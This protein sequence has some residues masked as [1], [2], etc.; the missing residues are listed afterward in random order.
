ML[1][2]RTVKLIAGV[3]VSALALAACSSNTP[4]A[5][6]STSAGGGVDSSAPAS[7]PADSSAP[8]ESEP[9]ESSAEGT[10]SGTGEALKVGLAFDTGGRG[11]GTFNDSAARGADRAK[12]E[13]GVTV[14]EVE[15]QSDDDRDPNLTLLTG[16]GLDPI[17]TVGFLW[18][19]TL[20]KIAAA[21]PDVTYA[22]VDGYV[23]APN[24]KN[25]GFAEEQGSFLVGAAAALKS[26]DGKIGFI[27]GQDGALIK[28]FELGY[29]AGAKA[30]NPD[31]EVKVQYLGPEGDNSAWGSPDKAKAIAKTWYDEGVDVIYSAAGGSGQGTID[32][33]IEAGEGKWAIGVDSD[34]YLTASPEAQKVILTSMLKRVDEAV[35]QTIEA[36]QNGNLD[37]IPAAFDLSVD[38]VGYSTEGG[39]IDEF[40]PQLEEFK[41]QIIAGDIVVPSS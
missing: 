25:L 12:A 16:Q 36:A 4:A 1:R 40:V 35:F 33:A 5:E 10:G 30:V 27:G 39:Y 11:D 13:L 32:A 19:D 38:G 17:V 8:A 9:A 15:A 20:A 18:S 26:A 7:E 37:S 21:N 3:A 31:I 23:D 22:I 14:T 2:S 41:A 24:V 28:K 34:Q 6:S 29:T